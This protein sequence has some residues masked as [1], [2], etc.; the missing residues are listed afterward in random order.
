VA[1]NVVDHTVEIVGGSCN[2]TL[3]KGTLGGG[4]SGVT[5]IPD[6][7]VLKFGTSSCYQVTYQRK[8][9]WISTVPT[10]VCP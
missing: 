6:G 3:L 10:T 1:G 7:T 9:T 4:I 2:I 5:D 8:T